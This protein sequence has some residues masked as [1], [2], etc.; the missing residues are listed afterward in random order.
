MI[1]VPA[2]PIPVQTAYA[3]PSGI[4]F[5]A[6][7]K[8]QK[9]IVPEIRKSPT[10]SHFEKP[11]ESFMHDVKPTSK[12]PASSSDSHGFKIDLLV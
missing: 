7:D 2:A 6:S 9:L 3:V 8:S 1:A 10:K 5:I 11:S 4:D 12:T